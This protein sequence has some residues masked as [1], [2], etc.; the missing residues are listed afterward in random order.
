M[1]SFVPFVVSGALAGALS[2]TDT[3]C[4]SASCRFGAGK[5]AGRERYEKVKGLPPYVPDVWRQALRF[6]FRSDDS[7][8]GH[9]AGHFHETRDVGS[10]H[11]VDVAVGLGSE[12]EAGV[13]IDDMIS[14][15]RRSTSS[16]PQF[17]FIA[18]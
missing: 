14:C 1:L 6:C 16:R 2:G 5:R 17:I 11:V 7:L 4:L 8:F 12:F 9:A 13:V 18:F 15:S 3:G 10:L